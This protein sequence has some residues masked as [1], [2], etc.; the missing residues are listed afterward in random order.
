MVMA[1]GSYASGS[2]VEVVPCRSIT[3]TWGWTGAP[4]PLAPGS[5]TVRITLEPDGDGTVIRLVHRDL[6]PELRPPH[7]EGWTHYT[8]RL[9]LVASGRDPGPD[10]IAA[11]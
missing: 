9:A 6:P 10:P 1:D 11:G 7:A 5:T 2:V 8:N 4:F 3:F